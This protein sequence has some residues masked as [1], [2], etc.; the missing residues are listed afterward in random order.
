MIITKDKIRTEGNSLI[1]RMQPAI[2]LL[3]LT[4][5]V[6]VESGVDGNTFF[7]KR[8]RYTL[9]AIDF[10]DWV[11]LSIQAILDIV[12]NPSD[13]LIIELQYV[14]N[15]TV[16]DQSS[17][18]V[19]SIEIEASKQAS[20]PLHYFDQTIFKDF[21]ENDSIEVLSWYLNV[22]DKLYNKGII[23]NYISRLNDFDSSEDF[24]DFWKS[25][26]KF[27][28]YY[29]VYARQFQ[30]FY[31]NEALLS[32]YIEQRGLTVSINNNI[33]QLNELMTNFYRQISNR[34]TNSIIDR[35]EDGKIIDGELLRLI[36]N[37]PEDEF[38][39]NLHKPEHFGWNIGNSSPL[40]RGLYLNSNANKYGDKN[41]EPIDESSYDGD[42]E[43]VQDGNL[44]VLRVYGT[45]GSSDRKIKVSADI[46]YEFSFLIKKQNEALLTV[47][48]E[49]YDAELNAVDLL[50]HRTGS[51]ETNFLTQIQLSRSDKYILVR[52][53]IFNKDKHVF[54]EDVTNTHQGENL[55]F[56]PNTKWIA[57]FIEI[58]GGEAYIYG[59]RFLP[60]NTPYSHGL[61][62][63]N[64]WISCW[65]ENKNNSMTIEE[66]ERFIKRYLIPY[67]SGIKVLE[68]KEQ[69][70][71]SGVEEEIE[72]FSWIGGGEY[73]ERFIWIG[74]EETA[75]CEQVVVP[76]TTTTTAAPTTTTTTVAPTTTTTTV[77]VTNQVGYDGLYAEGDT[78]H[79]EGGTLI[80]I[81]KFGTQQQ[82]NNI[83]MIGT[84]TLLRVTEVISSEG[85]EV[86][87]QP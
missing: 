51:A 12:V 16:E 43:I 74:E 15:G 64:N 5:F 86:I 45:L 53:F 73:C 76:T 27:F 83:Y 80:Y 62:Q 17:L 54:S 7:T 69:T 19:A 30:K 24:I 68:I 85:V 22:L 60:L 56:S 50:S 37:S 29:V 39:F 49:A 79:P 81:D 25:I 35:I 38:I 78:L 13:T 3:A 70:A 67:N 77:D 34:G 65:L 9:N 75:Y 18:N 4:S 46:D 40:Y 36:W 47:R 59:V 48:A 28:S 87:L 10:T 41:Y 8:F 2:G 82:I 66:I 57:P 84:Y 26:A 61:L 1:I 21:F 63:T 32:E 42:C 44:S 33:E 14:K 52:M 31:E 20:A 72:T 71:S 55:T 58:E 11:E 6:S 23:P